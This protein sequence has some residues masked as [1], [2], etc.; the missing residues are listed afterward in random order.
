M[1]REVGLGTEWHTDDSA[2]F[3]FAFA[4]SEKMEKKREVYRD[5]EWR[6]VPISE[7]WEMLREHVEKGDPV[8][9]ANFAMMIYIRERTGG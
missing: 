5:D 3:L 2:I 9:I 8:D 7:L 6:R 4:M 1:I